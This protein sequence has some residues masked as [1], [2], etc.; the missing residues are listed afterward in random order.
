[1]IY[2]ISVSN[3]ILY[4]IWTIWTFGPFSPPL[5]GLK[6]STGTF[7][8]KFLRLGPGHGERDD[9]QRASS[10]L[11]FTKNH[12]M[13]QWCSWSLNGIDHFEIFW[14]IQKRLNSANLSMWPQWFQRTSAL[15]RKWTVW[16]L[17]AGST[18]IP[19]QRVVKLNQVSIHESKKTE[20]CKC[21]CTYT[22]YICSK[23]QCIPSHT[24][25]DTGWK[26]SFLH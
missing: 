14:P 16:R 20:S 24:N 10:W 11:F 9:A 21:T 23:R 13:I 4:L 22:R 3:Y 7:T 2:S 17:W 8:T 6:I 18:A 26:I 25:M 12:R 1:M 15:Q 19:D 5:P